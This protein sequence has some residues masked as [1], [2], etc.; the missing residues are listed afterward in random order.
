[1]STSSD[2]ERDVDVFGSEYVQDAPKVWKRLR[3][4]CPVAHT[5]LHG[6]GWLPTTYADIS[7]IAYD[8]ENFSS[9]DVGVAA[10]PEGVALLVAPP[11]TCL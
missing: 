9:R 7:S 5:S 10:T 2:H 8:T 6:G 3:S 1:M 11:I 4:E